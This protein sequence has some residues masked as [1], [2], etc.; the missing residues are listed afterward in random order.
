VRAS[1]GAL[2]TDYAFT[3]QRFDGGTTLLDYGARWYDPTL[4]RF[5][6]ADSIVPEPGNP[7]SLNR[8]SYV[9]NNQ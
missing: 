3:G 5:L 7:Q 1:S 8:Y 6:A 2:P 9:L 4:G